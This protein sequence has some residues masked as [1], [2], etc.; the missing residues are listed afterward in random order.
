M[1]AKQKKNDPRLNLRLSAKQKAL[2]D[3]AA[4]VTGQS[5]CDFATRTLLEK[6]RRVVE[7]N[8]VLSNRDRDIFLAMLTSDSGPNHALL[9][10]AKRTS[11]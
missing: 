9:V 2:I 4:L 10:A 5:T 1:A 8:T 7:H 11:P 3:R 6:A